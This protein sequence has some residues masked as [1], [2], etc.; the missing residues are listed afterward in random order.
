[1]TKSLVGIGKV[2]DI[3]SGENKL[4]KNNKLHGLQS[5]NGF[6]VGNVEHLQILLW[7]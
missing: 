3:S 5:L 6:L 1:M 7:R 2:S 4:D